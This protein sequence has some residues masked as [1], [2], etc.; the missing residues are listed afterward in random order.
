MMSISF[1]SEDEF[2]YPLKSYFELLLMDYL[3]CSI[4]LPFSYGLTLFYRNSLSLIIV[5]VIAHWYL[6][7]FHS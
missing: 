6:S 5:N 1:L 2:L 7:V 4:V 3:K